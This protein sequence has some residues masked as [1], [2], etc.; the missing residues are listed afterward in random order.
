MPPST[1]QALQRSF[2][3]FLLGTCLPPLAQPPPEAQAALS[4][5]MTA[6]SWSSGGSAAAMALAR[7]LIAAGAGAAGG[8]GAGG[9]GVQLS[10]AQVAAD[11][12]IATAVLDCLC[13]TVLASCQ[14]APAEVSAKRVDSSHPSSS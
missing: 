8:Q 6:A 4:Q 5:A 11:L 2:H 7:S 12:E 1:W 13:D 10:P 9:G 3:V 14:H